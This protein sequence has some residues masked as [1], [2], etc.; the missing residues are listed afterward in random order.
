MTALLIALVDDGAGGQ[1]W[2]AMIG[3]SNPPVQWTFAGTD[4]DAQGENVQALAEAMINAEDTQLWDHM[5]DYLMIDP[6]DSNTVYNQMFADTEELWY[7][8]V[9]VYTVEIEDAA[10]SDLIEAAGQALFLELL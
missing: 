5:D 9:E 10:L 2:V 6:A 3:N 8:G 1:E 4:L 7:E